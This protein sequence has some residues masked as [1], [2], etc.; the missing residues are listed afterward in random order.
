ME[1]SFRELGPGPRSREWFPNYPVSKVNLQFH[2]R[3]VLG[4]PLGFTFYRA[5]ASGAFKAN[6]DSHN[7]K[8][9]VPD[10]AFSRDSFVRV[11]GKP[12]SHIGRRM[13]VSF[14]VR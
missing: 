5:G 4:L 14:S 12:D 8:I 11:F 2:V 7:P 3:A 9:V 13:A 10:S 6:R 1:V